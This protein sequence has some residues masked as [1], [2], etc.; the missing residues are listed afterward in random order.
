MRWLLSYIFFALLST[1]KS[2]SNDGRRLLVVIED[3]A[4]KDNYS[5]FWADLEGALS[6]GLE[7]GRRS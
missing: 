6:F 7:K 4:T 3:A 2:I 5:Q 1:V